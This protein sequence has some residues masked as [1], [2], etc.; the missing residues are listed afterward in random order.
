MEGFVRNVLRVAVTLSVYDPRRDG[1]ES[2]DGCSPMAA[3]GLA[4]VKGLQPVR[5]IGEK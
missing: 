1:K 3:T 4:N 5:P 2:G